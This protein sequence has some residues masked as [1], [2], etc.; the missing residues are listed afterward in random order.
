M[1]IINF[2]TLFDNFKK[3]RHNSTMKLFD[4][5]RLVKIKMNPQN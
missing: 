4:I 1:Q 3:F 5:K 2:V